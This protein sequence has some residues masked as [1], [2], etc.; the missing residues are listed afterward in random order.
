MRGLAYF[1]FILRSMVEVAILRN[2]GINAEMLVVFGRSLDET[3]SA[4]EKML[5]GLGFKHTG[6]PPIQGPSGAPPG[7][8]RNRRYFFLSE[9]SMGRVIVVQH[10]NSV[11]R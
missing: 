6:K 5:A 9:Y 10:S 1:A 3:F 2:V 11:E 8:R 4:L 7:P